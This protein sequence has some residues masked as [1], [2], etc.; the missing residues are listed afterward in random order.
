M[1]P[2]SRAE[3]S[4]GGTGPRSCVSAGIPL[5]AHVHGLNP[6]SFPSLSFTERFDLHDFLASTRQTRIISELPEGEWS[7]YSG[8]GGPSESILRI[9]RPVLPTPDLA[10]L[11]ASRPAPSRRC[12]VVH[13]RRLL[14]P[15]SSPELT[16]PDSRA[17]LSYRSRSGTLGRNRAP[18]LQAGDG[19][20]NRLRWLLTI[21]PQFA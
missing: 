1:K 2:V 3:D 20:D 21:C 9:S 19:P 18:I 14:L 13:V 15:N 7:F 17:T 11:F 6:T 10:G 8:P 5:A 16:C 12:S 4:V